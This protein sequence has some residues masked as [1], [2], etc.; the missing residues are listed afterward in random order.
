M[1][2]IKKQSIIIIN[3]LEIHLNKK[4]IYVIFYNIEKTKTLL[5]SKEFWIKKFCGES[6]QKQKF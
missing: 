2:I 6:L 4:T 1:C 5:Y 3:K